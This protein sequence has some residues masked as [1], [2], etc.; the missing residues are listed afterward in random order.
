VLSDTPAFSGPLKFSFV[1]AAKASDTGV[2]YGTVLWGFETFLDGGIAKIRNE[3]HSFRVVQGETMDAAIR[4]HSA[5]YKNPGTPGA[6][7]T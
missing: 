6:P 1:T 7:T 5:H 4:A 3:Y 2:W